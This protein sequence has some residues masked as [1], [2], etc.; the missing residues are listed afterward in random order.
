MCCVNIGAKSYA[1][2]NLKVKKISKIL[3][4]AAVIVFQ[5][6]TI[7]KFKSTLK[8]PQVLSKSYEVFV[9]ILVNPC[10]RLLNENR[11]E[12]AFV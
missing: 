7:K 11:I 5:V 10:F 12:F 9:T 6:F 2:T 1:K 8:H 3:S 4:T